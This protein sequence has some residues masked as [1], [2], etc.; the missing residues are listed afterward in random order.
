MN[1]DISWGQQGWI[2]PKCGC[3]YAPHVDE[4]RRCNC[5]SNNTIDTKTSPWLYDSYPS[6]M[7]KDTVSS[8]AVAYGRYAE[9]EGQPAIITNA[10][11]ILDYFDKSEIIN[12]ET[13]NSYFNKE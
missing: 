11:H 5:G 6:S 3:V 10:K 4:C 2:C 8:N 9:Y 12:E 1:T 7:C 13:I